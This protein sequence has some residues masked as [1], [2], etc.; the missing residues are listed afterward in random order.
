M[1]CSMVTS[2]GKGS[3]HFGKVSGEQKLTYLASGPLIETIDCTEQLSEDILTQHETY[4]TSM[5]SEWELK[6]PVISKVQEWFALAAEET[7]LENRM[8]DPNRFK[9]GGAAM[10]QEEKMR[11]RVNLLKPKVC[12]ISQR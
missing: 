6:S 4:L 12:R 5:Q 1:P 9:K 7:E 2:K 11:K 10:L 8:L 3:R